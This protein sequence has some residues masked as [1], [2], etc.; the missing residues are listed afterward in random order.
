MKKLLIMLLIC[1][2]ITAFAQKTNFTGKWLI[3]KSKIDFGQA[4]E[5]IVPKSIQIEQGTD[6]ITVTKTNLN[7]ELKDLVPVTDRLTFDS[8]PFERTTAAGLLVTSSLKW[9][10]DSSF[11]ISLKTTKQQAT[12]TWNL[13]D[14]GKTLTINREVEQT[15]GLKY[16]VRCFYDKQ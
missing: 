8:K 6:K 14:S 7:P 15:D 10:N 2:S 13:E 12:E 1:S 5:W 4:P 9:L 3:N 16:T 11:T